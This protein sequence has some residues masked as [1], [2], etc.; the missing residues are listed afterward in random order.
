VAKYDTERFR[1][2]KNNHLEDD[3]ILIFKKTFLLFWIPQVI[4]EV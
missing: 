3:L 1:Q 2:K 4:G